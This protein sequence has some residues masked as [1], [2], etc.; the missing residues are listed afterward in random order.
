MEKIEDQ[1]IVGCGSWMDGLWIQH[2]RNFGKKKKES[3]KS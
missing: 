1:T 2:L 3:N